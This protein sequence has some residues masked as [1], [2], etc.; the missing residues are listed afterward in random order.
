MKFMIN[1]YTKEA[2]NIYI[3]AVILKTTLMTY[4]PL[5]DPVIALTQRI[6]DTKDIDEIVVCKISLR[7]SNVGPIIGP[8][9]P[10]I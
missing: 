2:W 5:K 7:S 6:M 4:V 10:L 3:S 8:H 9:K 1:D